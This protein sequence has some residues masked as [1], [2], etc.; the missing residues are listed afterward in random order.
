MFRVSRGWIYEVDGVK[1]CQP[2]CGCFNYIVV[3]VRLSL[4]T[5]KGYLLVWR[6]AD[7][8]RT[9]K[10]SI[11][12][13]LVSWSVR[14]ICISSMAHTRSRLA[15]GCRAASERGSCVTWWELRR[16]GG[17]TDG[18]FR[19]I[20][21]YPN[22]PIRQTG[23][24]LLAIGPIHRSHLQQL[25]CVNIQ[26]VFDLIFEIPWLLRYVR[27]VRSSTSTAVTWSIRKFF[28]RLF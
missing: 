2:V 21:L 14:D 12:T 28:Y 27:V 10:L 16:S 1:C 17:Q 8:R 23:D 20:R 9:E 7:R 15:A 4:A 18:A 11:C 19:L 22:K 6:I 24:V 5:I 13:P 25:R 3:L 26:D